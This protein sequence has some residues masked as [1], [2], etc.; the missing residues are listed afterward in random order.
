MIGRWARRVTVRNQNHARRRRNPIDCG[1]RPASATPICGPPSP[2]A[3]SSLLHLD[4]P[5]HH[6]RSRMGRR[7]RGSAAHDPLPDPGAD[8]QL[9]ELL[10]AAIPLPQ[11]IPPPVTALDPPR[12]TG[13]PISLAGSGGLNESRRGN[14]GSHGQSG[15]EHPHDT[16]PS[17]VHFLIVCQ[18]SY[19]SERPQLHPT[20]VDPHN[21][22]V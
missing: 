7:A 2:T 10:G 5:C 6:S 11:G 13:V 3:W 8:W 17:I 4:Q 12:L 19:F 18:G 14:E 20:Q 16:S 1:R 21:L 22:L 9:S 15:D